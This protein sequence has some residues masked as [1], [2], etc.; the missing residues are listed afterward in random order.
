MFEQQIQELDQ[1]RDALLVE[2]RSLTEVGLEGPSLER[3][4]TIEGEVTDIKRRRDAIE[5][6]AQGIGDGSMTRTP[7]DQSDGERGP[8]HLRRVD[9]WQER[10]YSDT[11][12][13][14]KNR[15]LAAL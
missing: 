12:D 13:D 15:G 4:V 1:Q 7:G 9:P 11:L 6:A 10:H 3:F 2:A 5:R 14:I 8:Q